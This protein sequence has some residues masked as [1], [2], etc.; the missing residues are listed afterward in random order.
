[1]QCFDSGE[2]TLM[3]AD[4]GGVMRADDDGRWWGGDFLLRQGMFYFGVLN[5]TYIYWD[6]MCLC[7]NP[8]IDVV[9]ES[10]WPEWSGVDLIE[11]L[12]I[13]VS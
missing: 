8:H 6:G 10:S 1:M 9:T 7:A 4:W 5:F 3:N 11:C 12:H 2:N 13:V